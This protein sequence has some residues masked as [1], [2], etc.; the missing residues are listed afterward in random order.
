MG[1][2][3]EKPTVGM[4]LVCM[5]L[6]GHRLH[7]FFL[8]HSYTKG[9]NPRVVRMGAT[10]LSEAA[11]AGGWTETV[12]PDVSTRDALLAH[13]YADGVARW[14]TQHNMW[15]ISSDGDRYLVYHEHHMDQADSYHNAAYH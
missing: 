12:R 14:S 15:C 2:I 11:N 9:G 13:K 8:V 7:S 5:P 10:V 4:V 1:F 6:H 3:K